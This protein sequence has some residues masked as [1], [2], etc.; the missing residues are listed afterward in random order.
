VTGSGADRVGR[1]IARR[2]VESGYRVVLHAHSSLDEVTATTKAW[3]A[4]GHAVSFVSGAVDD[5]Q[6]VAA[7]IE[8]IVSQHGGLHA[9]V[10]SAATWDATP[11][12]S[13]DSDALAAQWRV[14]LLG[15][16]LLCRAAGL[17]MAEQSHG[18]AIVN[19]G[20]WAVIRPYPD[21]S[22]YMLSKGGL[23]TLTAVMAVE[24]AKR[25]PCIRVNAVLPGPV[26]LDE[27]IRPEAREKIIQQSLLKRAGS[28]EDVAAA[29]KFLIESPFITGVCLPVDGGRSIYS[30]DSEDIAAHPS[31]QRGKLT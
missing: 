21:F 18:G 20:D 22:A 14:N 9:L 31:Y 2:L 27:N 6:T 15:P 11:L 5:Q 8:E 24:L 13:L 10:N 7:W 28:A 29:V 12:E 3:R 19:I 16:T 25:Q 4:E 26:M 30:G 1:C 23:R 17:R